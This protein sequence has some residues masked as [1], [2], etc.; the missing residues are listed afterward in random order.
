MAGKKTTTK[1]AVKKPAAKEP[2]KETAT[3]KKV[4]KARRP[5]LYDGRVFKTGEAI[6]YRD[7]K[8]DAWIKDG[9]AGWE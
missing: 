8:I 4:L 6:P 9:S 3:A 5:L 2:A 1:A 7:E